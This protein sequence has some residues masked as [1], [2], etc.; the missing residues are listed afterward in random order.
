MDYRALATKA[1]QERG[2]DPNLYLALIQQESGFNPTAESPV[3]AYG[4]TQVMPATASDPGWGIAPLSNRDDPN[5]QIRF[6]A[7]YLDAM[8]GR[9]DGDTSKALAAY[10]WGAG[11]ADKWD[12]DLSSLPEETQGYIRNITANAGLPDGPTLSRAGAGLPLDTRGYPD[13]GRDMPP[14]IPSFYEDEY[15]DNWLGRVSKSKD[16][17]RAGLGDKL[18]L[19]AKQM[20]NMG[21]GLQ[22]LGG[23]ISQGG[24]G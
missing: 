20:G 18:G 15:A 2:I 13:K 6:G 9:Y 10:N 24:F 1:A 23:F 7:D 4:L 3:G 19:D 17:M 16:T 5:E 12:G 8:L 21:K 22:G 11:N 14:E